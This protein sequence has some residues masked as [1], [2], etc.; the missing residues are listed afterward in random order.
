[1]PFDERPIENEQVDQEEIWSA[2]R[3]LDPDG[4]VQDREAQS[5]TMIAVLGLL[6]TVCAVG[7]LVWVRVLG[8]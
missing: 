5:A 6:L 8:L 4:R 7:V 1:M 3:Y 2:I